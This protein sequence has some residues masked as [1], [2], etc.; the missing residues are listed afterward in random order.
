MKAILHLA[1][2]ATF[3]GQI[4]IFKIRGKFAST[5]AYEDHFV[6]PKVK[7]LLVTH[8]RVLLLQVRPFLL[9]MC[10]FFFT[11]QSDFI[12]CLHSWFQLPMMTQRKFNPAKD[13]CSVIWDVLWDDLVTVEMTHGKKDPPGSLPSKLIL[14]LKARPSNSKEVV[15]L[16]KCNRG[17]D[18]AT[19]I[20]SAID[21]AYKAYG[22]NSVKVH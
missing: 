12:T 4:D 10:H 17:S 14:Y 1:E 21:K 13:P 19:I 22:P 16:V 11:C 15:R 3:L 9:M 20:Y 7:I 6:L 18:Q 5:D 8:R 2:C